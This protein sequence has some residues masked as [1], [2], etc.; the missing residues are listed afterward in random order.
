MPEKFSFLKPKKRETPLDG[1]RYMVSNLVIEKTEAVL[2]DYRNKNEPSEGLVYWAGK[3]QG[4]LII[5]SG[6]IA[7]KILSHA[8]G[9]DI[10][11]SHYSNV[12]NFLSENKIIQLGQVHSHPGTWVDHSVYDDRGATSKVEGLLSIVVPKYG[13]Q[14]MRPLKNCGVHRFAKE[15]F[16]RLSEK[17]IEEHF[18]I[19]GDTRFQFGDFR[20]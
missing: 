11:N 7:P 14:G 15:T 16:I 1:L 12:V 8:Q 4:E 10:P 2:S 18:Q 9:I 5:I 6:V 3:R 20:I 13:S 19:S 17:Y